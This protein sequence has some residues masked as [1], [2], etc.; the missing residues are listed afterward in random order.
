MSCGGYGYGP[1]G[2]GRSGG[3]AEALAEATAEIFFHCQKAFMRS[4]LWEP[5]TW[6]PDALPSHAAL[7]KAVQDTPETLE[8]LEE[9]YAPANYSQRLY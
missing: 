9:Y 6:R 4:K 1:G 7:A 2:F 5:E 8:E 3:G